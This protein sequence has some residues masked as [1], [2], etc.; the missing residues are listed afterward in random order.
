M[1]IGGLAMA[2]AVF[3]FMQWMDSVT[4]TERRRVQQLREQ[5]IEQTGDAK[6]CWEKYG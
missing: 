4:N 3:C 2:A 1:F 5:C 6:Y